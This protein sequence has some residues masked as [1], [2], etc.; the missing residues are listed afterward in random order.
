MQEKIKEIDDFFHSTY[1]NTFVRKSMQKLYTKS[2][3]VKFIGELSKNQMHGYG[4]VFWPNGALCLA[5]NFCK[6]QPHAEYMI[7]LSFNDQKLLF[8]GKCEHSF[9]KEGKL[10]HD[11]GVLLYNGKFFKDEID[12]QNCQVYYKNG[13]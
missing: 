12:G 9:K 1:A 8:A 2:G 7:K 3:Q 11:N 5:G 10:F 6:D 4:K 13:N